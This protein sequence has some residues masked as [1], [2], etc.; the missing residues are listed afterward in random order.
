MSNKNPPPGSAIAQ[1]MAQGV[2]RCTK[3]VELVNKIAD[4][5]AGNDIKHAIQATMYSA[6]ADDIHHWLADRDP[7]LA[8]ELDAMIEKYQEEDEDF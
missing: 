5:F 8:V 2:A 6:V 3:N 7:K 4:A 1:D